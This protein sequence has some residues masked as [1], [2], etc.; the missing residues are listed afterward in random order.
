MLEQ[1]LKTLLWWDDMQLPMQ[2]KFLP[3]GQ[4]RAR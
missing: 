3:T 4:V 1:D 2:I